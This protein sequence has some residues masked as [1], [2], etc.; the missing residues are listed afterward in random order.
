MID[1]I[2]KRKLTHNGKPYAK[3]AKVPMTVQQYE[4]DF[5]PNG[6]G[7]VERPS[8]K[9]KAAPKR[10]ASAKPKAKAATA[11]AAPPPALIHDEPKPATA[12]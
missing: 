4:E 9:P 1:T 8:N 11:T 3:G 10:N 5:G 7:W 12:D 6:I 2:A